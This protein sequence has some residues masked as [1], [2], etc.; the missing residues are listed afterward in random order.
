MSEEKLT[1]VI[2]HV[3]VAREVK[4][5]KLILAEIPENRW[6]ALDDVLL[7][8]NGDLA[9]VQCDMQYLAPKELCLLKEMMQQE[10]LHHPVGCSTML[11]W[12]EHTNNGG[13][14]E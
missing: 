6:A 9:V 1:C 12:N 13:N 2:T 14:Q 8:E 7:L 10:P 4:S 5:G 11:M 3:V